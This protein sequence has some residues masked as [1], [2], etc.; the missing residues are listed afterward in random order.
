MYVQLNRDKLNCS[1][2]QWCESL[3]NYAIF[4]DLLMLII[5]FLGLQ[6]SDDSSTL[7]GVTSLR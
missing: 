3:T 7:G 1:Y 5:G 2:N 6:S 4:I